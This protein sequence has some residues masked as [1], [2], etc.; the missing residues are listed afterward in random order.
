MTRVVVISALNLLT[1]DRSAE[2]RHVRLFLVALHDLLEVRLDDHEH[3]AH[4]VARELVSVRE[5]ESFL[6]RDIQERLANQHKPGRRVVESQ[7]F[8]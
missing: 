5:I 8:T 7:Q 6:A 3:A 2:S 4:D 1:N